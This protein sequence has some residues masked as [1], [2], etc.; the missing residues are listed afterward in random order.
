[1]ART[2]KKRKSQ[3][4]AK[5]ASPT[6][7]AK[8]RKKPSSSRPASGKSST[9]VVV[10]SPAKARTI[11]KYL[12]PGFSVKATVG[13]I[14]DLPQ[15][16]LGV[17][18]DK[19]FRP[20]YVT[21]RGKGKQLAAIMRAAKDADAVLLATDPDREGEAIAW[22]VADQLNDGANI[23]RVRFHE[24]TKAAIREAIQHPEQ[25]DQ[26]KVDAQQARRI[27]DR[28]VGYKASPLLW[29]S[30]KRGLSAGRVQTVALRLIVER[31]QAIR[32]FKPQEY[33]SIEADL[34]AKKKRF[35]AKLH[36]IRG[37]KPA[38]QTEKEA[39][40]VVDAVR[41]QP[42]VVSQVER[43]QR[44][45][46]PGPPFI[47]ST[48]QQEA[49]KR[50]GFSAKRT[51]RAA[52][53]LYEGVELGKEGA[54][55]L[56]TYM[57][58]DSPRVADV[59]I[60]AVRDFIAGAYADRYLPAKPNHYSSKK[61]ARAQEAH[62]AIRPTDVLRKPADLKAF[63]SAD[64]HRLYQLIWLRFVA[65][66][67]MPAVYDTSAIDFELGT[68][69]FRATG[70]VLIFDGFHVLYTD[71]KEEGEEQTFEDLSPVPSLKKGDEAKVHAITPSQHFTEPPPRFSEASLVKELEGDGIGRPST[72]AAIIS[73]LRER[74]YVLVD[75][76][77]FHTTE[78]G[79]TVARVMVGQ[80]PDI[81]N[82]EFTSEMETELDKIEEGAL[83][84]QKVLENF[85]GPFAKALE[86]IDTTA[87]IREA[88]GVED[89][90]K[91]P[92]PE[93]GGKLTLKSGRFGPFIACTKYPECRYTK[94]LKRDKVPDKPTDEV[95]A[96]CGAPMVVKTGRYGEFLA[97][98]QYPKC[99]HTRPIPL[100]VTCT[101]CGTGDLIERRTRRGRS[102]FGCSRYP[103][104][105]FSTWHR[106]VPDVCP[107]CGNLGAERRVSKARG[108]YRRCLKCEDEFE[109]EGATAESTAE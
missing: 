18:V 59:A 103:E 20:K 46:R 3:K 79:E 73:T 106:P 41:G 4:T 8:S 37:K 72:Y 38:L 60:A 104:C 56:I 68:Y 87:L 22:H 80:F 64:Q 81:F 100:G 25:I 69:L 95:C 19:G 33:W 35:T 76:R 7:T 17:D 30:V 27:L 62:E 109:V 94:P 23:Q 49:A 36:K 14:R 10:E 101:K 45:K 82:V 92:C 66:Q 50:L 108:E 63:L 91:E 28:L 47:T 85:Y 77:R 75:R 55:G 99:K 42:F 32:D 78:L 9:L 97:C 70:S 88:H 52:Q 58:T 71:T 67:M 61:A 93:C 89:L 2:T 54:V 21:I 34:E 53:D 107:S 90:E 39:R 43:K 40:A 13:H 31:E 51:M 65:S 6:S 74:G 102:F 98:T 96:E 5:R 12:D 24:I 84:W 44:K 83:S 16:E 105:D 57:R 15:R 11:T 86:S 29:K 1:M 26:R 48:L